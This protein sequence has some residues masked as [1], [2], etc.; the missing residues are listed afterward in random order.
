MKKSQESSPRRKI[1]LNV[2]E[3]IFLTLKL[4][5]EQEHRSLN[6]QIIF[7]LLGGKPPQQV[8]AEAQD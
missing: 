4:M 7:L 8:E 5:A 3:E 2:P 6:Q 1:S